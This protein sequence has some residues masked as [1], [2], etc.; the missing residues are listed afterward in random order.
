MNP[1][2]MRVIAIVVLLMSETVRAE[3]SQSQRSI[4]GTSETL[5]ANEWELGLS[6]TH[7]GLSDD[8]M[9]SA[10]SLA[11]LV[12]Y[13]RVEIRHRMKLEGS[14]QASPYVFAET[15]RKYGAG[16]NFGFG[17]GE[18]RQHSLTLGGRIQFT[19]RLHGT[20]H[21]PRSRLHTQALP[22]VEYDFYSR[23]NVTYV[24]IADYILYFG[25]TWA[26]DF[27][28]IGL[29]ASPRSGMIPLPYVYVR[30]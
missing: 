14:S 29:I 8:W 25:H 11:S 18:S 1:N 5:Q 6:S 2:P 13:G 16:T 4:N 7:V 23:G 10:P 20:T 27:W 30:F 9:L 19:P 17:F 28:H 22:N 15:P 3:F 21:G 12:G 24:G 26:F